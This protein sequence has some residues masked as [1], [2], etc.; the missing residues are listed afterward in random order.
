MKR[1]RCSAWLGKT[2]QALGQKGSVLSY[3]A[4]NDT[5]GY[6][7]A[8][9]HRNSEIKWL[10]IR[11]CKSLYFNMEICLGW[12]ANLLTFSYFRAKGISLSR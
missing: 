10:F 6:G 2:D 5:I 3:G 4:H 7:E 1:F 12:V 8:C 11:R 9:K